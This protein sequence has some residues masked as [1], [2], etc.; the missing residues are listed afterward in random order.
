MMKT[1]FFFLALFLIP[2]TLNAQVVLNEWSDI[3]FNKYNVD[4]FKKLN[5]VQQKINSKEIDYQLLNAAIFYRTN[6]ERL[7]NGRTEFVHSTALEKSAFAYSKDMVQKNFY[8]HDSPIRGRETMTKRLA[9]VGI[10][11]TDSA[12]NIYDFFE[13]D[14]TYWSIA[15]KLVDGWMKS[16]G[17]RVNILNQAYRY[18]GC[19]AFHYINRE[20]LD[21][22]WVKSTQ[23]FS[24]SDAIK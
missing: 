6:E 2:F 7:K 3:D 14:P 9:L 11:N 4:S 13:V 24:S 1:V 21:Y 15:D 22:F 20:W 18:L 17:H 8:S 10:N 19:G 12:E 16:P 23:N 5:I